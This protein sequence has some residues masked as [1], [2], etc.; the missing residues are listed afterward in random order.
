MRFAVKTR[1]FR[2]ATHRSFPLPNSTA[3]NGLLMIDEGILPCHRF[4]EKL[5]A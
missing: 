2:G 4:P 1:Q 3:Y 5:F